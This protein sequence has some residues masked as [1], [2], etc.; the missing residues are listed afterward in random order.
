MYDLTRSGP[1]KV[2]RTSNCERSIP[3]A[4]GQR[5]VDIKPNKR[6]R[7]EALMC[8]RC[9]FRVSSQ[10]TRPLGPT[11]SLLQDCGTGSVVA[12]VLGGRNGSQIIIYL[13]HDDK[14]Y[15]QGVY[16]Q[17]LEVFSELNGK[18]SHASFSHF[19]EFLIHYILDSVTA[20]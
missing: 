7:R 16:E 11:T 13:I 17:N 3:I 20:Y 5:T 19:E 12:G 4:I 2:Q 10:I 8:V 9:T 6:A 15:M 14:R 1:G 18:F